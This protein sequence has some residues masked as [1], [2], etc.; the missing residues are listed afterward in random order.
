MIQIESMPALCNVPKSPNIF[1]TWSEAVSV[2]HMEPHET[3]CSSEGHQVLLYKITFRLHVHGIYE[4]YINVLFSLDLLPKTPYYVYVNIPKSKN[5][6]NPKRSGSRYSA[7]EAVGYVT[8]YTVTHKDHWFSMS[9]SVLWKRL[10]ASI[11]GD[12]GMGLNCN[13]WSSVST[14]RNLTTRTS[15]DPLKYLLLGIDGKLI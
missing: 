6:W 13:L 9:V 2:N 14:A 1:E 10:P 3:G 4:R 15:W 11:G 5:I 7:S 12:L 8:E